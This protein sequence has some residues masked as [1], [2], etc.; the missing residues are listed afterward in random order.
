MWAFVNIFFYLS[1]ICYNIWPNVTLYN[2]VHVVFI[3]LSYDTEV[4]CIR[5]NTCRY[6]FSLTQ[7]CDENYI[8]LLSHCLWELILCTSCWP[9]F[10]LI[11]VYVKYCVIAQN[12]RSSWVCLRRKASEDHSSHFA[13]TP[14]LKSSCVLSW[15]HYQV[16]NYSQQ[17]NVPRGFIF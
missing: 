3:Y 8:F 6:L 7:L 16:W 17:W 9:N 15:K 1:V 5:C 12:F 10:F 11:G 4:W 2:S 13:S 14:P